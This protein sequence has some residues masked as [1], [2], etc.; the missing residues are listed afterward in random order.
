[1][2]GRFATLLLG[3]VYF[4]AFV[5][6]RLIGSR[7]ESRT[8]QW[9]RRLEYGR[10]VRGTPALAA[11]AL[12]LGAAGW[13]VSS[14]D[15]LEGVYADRLHAALVAEEYAVAQLCGERLMGLDPRREV[16]AYSL[17][18][19][20]AGLGDILRA[21]ALMHRLAPADAEGY[22]P[23]QLWIVERRL[24]A[25]PPFSP[26]DLRGLEARLIRLRDVPDYGADAAR[27]SADL[28]FRTGR[29]AMV[30][31]EP[32]LLAAAERTP[33]LR[34][35]LTEAR[36]PTTAPAVTK[37]VG[38]E[39]VAEFRRRLQ[40]RPDDV[41]SRLHLARS[42]LLAGR[43]GAARAVLQEGLA[44]QDDRRLGTSLAAIDLEL[45][46]LAM[47]QGAP[48]G[49][50][51]DLARKALDSL[52]AHAAAGDA[53]TLERARLLAALGEF[54]QAREAYR[55][56]LAVYPVAHVELAESYAA[57][58][59][60]DDASREYREVLRWYAAADPRQRREMP[61]ARV[62]GP[63]A[64]VRLGE[65][66][67]AVEWLRSQASDGGPDAP[68]MKVLLAQACASWSDVL[69]KSS[70]AAIGEQRLTLL[71]EALE[72][73][74]FDPAVLQRLLDLAATDDAVGPKARDR[75]HRMIVE[76]RAPASAYLLAGT[77]ALGRGARDEGLRYLEQ[78]FRLNPDSYA[79][80]NNL[81]WGLASGDKPDLP[82]A[83][84][85][86]DEAR[87]KAPN[88]LNVRDTRGRILA[89]LKRWPEA[90]AELEAAAPLL[91]GH[92]EYH[93]AT[94]EVYDAMNLHDLARQARDAARQA[95]PSPDAKP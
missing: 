87:R 48:S 6:Q 5:V 20:Y 75:F 72:A 37:A 88:D 55:G 10:F 89:K 90:L 51:R 2:M 58:G 13:W 31:G 69:G 93:R 61:Q 33:S 12:A 53:S 67:Q 57:R 42:E 74:P 82:R 25:G 35:P 29:A 60:A 50:R 26:D 18:T 70:G 62:A 21:E 17:A 52:D 8:G 81:A 19:A 59:Q 84:T 85:L 68:L 80:L 65:F 56:V 45:F 27:V 23:A 77:D 7:R 83:L 86:I 40:T 71:A 92:A 28:Y 76:G 1:M 47:R 66:A 39:L 95:Q 44:L 94:A 4:S 91:R 32:T 79:A 64:A 34:L 24:R 46:R 36:A 41:E 30:L 3:P 54:D 22:P 63:L 16:Y 9:A 11:A 43:F 49:V 14:A 73:A 15:R 78:A 38:E